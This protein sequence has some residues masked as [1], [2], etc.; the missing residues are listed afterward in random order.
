VSEKPRYP[1]DLNPVALEPHYSRHMNSMT[2][3]RLEG[4][5]AIA[6]QLALRD[7]EIE[8]LRTQLQDARNVQ[9][10]LARGYREEHE[11]I[12]PLLAACQPRNGG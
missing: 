8:N 7:Q 3:E 2:A 4:K 9:A 11:R 1:T 12:A 6:E 5:A 10:E